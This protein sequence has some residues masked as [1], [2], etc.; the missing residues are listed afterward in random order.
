MEFIDLKSQ[1]LQLTSSGETLRED[2]EKRIKNVLNHGKYILGP[3]VKELEQ[4]LAEYV[5]VDN[6]IAISSGTDAL[7]VSLMA[8]GINKNDEVI[9]T[10]FS[11][12]S[13]VETIILLGAIPVFVDI[14]PRTFNI[15]P[16]KIL[17]AINNRTKAIIPVSLYG[18]PADFTEI[19]KIA[20]SYNIPVIEDGAQSFGSTHNKIKSGA[21]STIGATSFFPSKPLG[22]YGDGGACFTNDKE[23]AKKIRQISLHGQ[24]KRYHHQMIGI[25]GRLDSIQAAI[26]LAKFDIFDEE[27]K[28]REII[29]NRYTS[30]LNKYG[31][32]GTPLIESNNTTIY[33]QYTIQVNNRDQIIKK[34]NEKGIPTSVHYPILISEQDA[35]NEK[36]GRKKNI[37]KRIFSK[38]MFRS[39]PINNALHASKKVLSLPMYPNLS[40]DDQDLVIKSLIAVLN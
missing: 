35:L 37:L 31:F 1:Q 34:L 5:G 40:K 3:E 38:K 32:L 23:L 27:V 19:N 4:K 10:P 28:L 9:T 14:D 24:S 29:G 2:I 13:T 11:F 21:L 39:Y 15:N 25:N 7:L 30:E 20:K 12:F 22:G 18:Q 16:K 33:G 36:L 17:P 6:C 26:I 8:L